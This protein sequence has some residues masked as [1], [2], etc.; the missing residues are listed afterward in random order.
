LFGRFLGSG[1]SVGTKLFPGLRHYL[2]RGLRVRWGTSKVHR[3]QSG[4]GK[5]QQTK[6]CHDGLCPREILGEKVLAGRCVDAKV[7]ANKVSANNAVINVWRSTNT[8]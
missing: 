6:F 8:R 5:Q 4:G 1:F 2:R 7:L 3:R